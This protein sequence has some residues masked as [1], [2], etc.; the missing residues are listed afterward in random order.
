MARVLRRRAARLGGA[1]P[2]SGDHCLMRTVLRV[3][4]LV[5]FAVGCGAPEPTP[6]PVAEAESMPPPDADADAG[7]GAGT[8]LRVDPQLDA[9]VPPDAHIEKLA[10][11]FVFT[12]GPVWSRIESRL[13]FSDVRGNTIYEWT[14]ADGASPFIDPVFEGDRTGLRSVSS[15][16]LTFDTTGLV[17]GRSAP[18][19]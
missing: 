10:D 7:A 15:N 18:T 16:G 11:G 2:G 5:C 1:L 9:L 19:G 14:E 3:C 6:P 12:E 4:V 8:I 13:L 17:C